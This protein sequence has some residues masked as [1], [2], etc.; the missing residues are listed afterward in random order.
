MHYFGFIFLS[1]W[2]TLSAAI[3]ITRYVTPARTYCSGF[4][5]WTAHVLFCPGTLLVNLWRLFV[6]LPAWCLHQWVGLFLQPELPP[7]VPESLRAQVEAVTVF[8][9]HGGLSA[10]PT[11]SINPPADK[12]PR[13]RKSKAAA[14]PEP[15]AQPTNLDE[16]R[17][18]SL[19]WKI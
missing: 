11:A 7:I 15:E 14:K 19:A 4:P 9:S 8:V 3:Q 5:A 12:P 1:T 6:K 17:P 2:V 16:A 10:V 18:T 13:T